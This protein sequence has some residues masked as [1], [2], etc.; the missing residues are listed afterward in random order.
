MVLTH[1]NGDVWLYFG[2]L[3]FFVFHLLLLVLLI[4]LNPMVDFCDR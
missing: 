2:V 4:L 1:K 3:Q